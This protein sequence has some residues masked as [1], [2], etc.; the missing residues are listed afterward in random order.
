MKE[1]FQEFRFQK[2]SM[3]II[4]TANSIIEEYRRQGYSLTLRQLYY[5]FVARGLIPNTIQEYK[6]LGS[7]VNKGRLAGLIDWMAIE[8]RT[9]N[10][11]AYGSSGS[12]EDTIYS[13]AESHW[14]NPWNNQEYQPEVWVEKE[15]LVGVI[16]KACSELYLPFFACRG[17]VSQSEQWR[18]GRRFEGAIQN[19]RIPIVLHLGDHDPSGIDMTRDNTE[20]LGMFAGKPVEVRRLALNYDQIETYKPPPNPAKETDSRCAGYVAKYGRSSW[21]LDALDP[22]V[23]RKLIVDEVNPLIDWG[24]WNSVE[25]QSK[26]ERDALMKIAHNYEAVVEFVADAE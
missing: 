3:K 5:Q 14:L 18:A 10:L 21:E 13:A 19:G 24:E 15:A 17:F 2:A 9:R 20:R 11:R 25:T 8:D 1:A 4:D 16:E 22:K 7:V 23:I 12:P 6:R 26:M